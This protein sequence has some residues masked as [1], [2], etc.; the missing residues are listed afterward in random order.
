[1]AMTK[2]EQRRRCSELETAKQ[3]EQLSSRELEEYRQT[4]IAV[5]AASVH[6][7]E[8]KIKE[9]TVAHL[10]SRRVLERNRRLGNGAAISRDEIDRATEAEALA[11]NR[12]EQA[13][14]CRDRTLIELQAAEERKVFVQRDPTYLT[15]YLQ[16]RQ[17][18]PQ[19]EAQLVETEERLGAMVAQIKQVEEHANRL[20]GSTIRSPVLGVVWSRN[21]SWGPVAKGEALLEIAQTQRQFIE[22]LFPERHAGSLYPGAKAVILFSGLPPFE[23]SVR[24]VR[25]PSPTDHDWAYAIRLPRRLNQLEVLIDF[26]SPPSDASLLGRQCQVLAAGPSNSTH[27]WA[28]KLFCLL[29]W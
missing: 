11:R 29:R 16:A 12:L 25:Q 17:S 23:G 20:A 19:I 24:A 5:L 21:A 9:L 1:M 6:E 10:Q 3:L 15:W 28:A 13:Q 8:A 18:I 2:A 27:G 22:A 7:T 26:D 4:L 14:A